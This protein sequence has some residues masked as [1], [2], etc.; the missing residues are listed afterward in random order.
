M[1][2]QQKNIYENITTT[3]RKAKKKTYSLD[4]KFIEYR[5]IY[6]KYIVEDI[7]QVNFI[8]KFR[9]ILNFTLNLKLSTKFT[10]LIMN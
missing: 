6:L 5:C 9:Q 2:K 3:N 1:A 10:T 4:T 7:T 8:L